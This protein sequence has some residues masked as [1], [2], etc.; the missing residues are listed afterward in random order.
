MLFHIT[1]VWIDLFEFIY[2]YKHQ[3]DGLA[4]LIKIL[5]LLKTTYSL[6]RNNIFCYGNSL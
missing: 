5:Q 3:L 4:E 6:Y 2:R 1:S